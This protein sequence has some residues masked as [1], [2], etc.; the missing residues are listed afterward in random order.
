MLSSTQTTEVRKDQY[1]MTRI[2]GRPEPPERH[3]LLF[4][5]SSS[6]R[7]ISWTL[8]IG[9]RFWCVWQAQNGER[10]FLWRLWIVLFAEFFLSV[11]DILTTTGIIYPLFTLQRFPVRPRY[12]LVG[13]PAPTIDVCVTCCGEPTDVVADTLAGAA[14][15]DYPRDRFRIL[16]L[17]DGGDAKL[18]EAVEVLAKRHVNGPQI[19]YRSRKLAPG[20]QSY[21]K[22]GNLQYGLKETKKLGNLQYF[23][24]LDADMIPASDWLRKVIPHLILDDKVALACPPQVRNSHSFQIPVFYPIFVFIA[25]SPYLF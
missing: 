18:E 12:C 8:Y 1:H 21:Y 7:V 17:D 9:H 14:A 5:G 19:L 2:P 4:I 6:V 22:A 3:P 15:Q 20:V 16:L 11:E 10:I 25:E 23:A 13:N 24:V